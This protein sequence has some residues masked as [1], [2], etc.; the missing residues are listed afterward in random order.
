MSDRGLTSIPAPRCQPLPCPSPP[1]PSFYGPPAP[2]SLCLLS[3]APSPFRSKVQA[4]G[5]Q[6]TF[7]GA[8]LPKAAPHCKDHLP[9]LSLPTV[10]CMTPHMGPCHHTTPSFPGPSPQILIPPTSSLISPIH[11]NRCQIPALA[12]AS[13]RMLWGL[14]PPRRDFGHLMTTPLSPP[15]P[16]IFLLPFPSSPYH[17]PTLPPLKHFPEPPPALFFLS[18]SLGMG[19][20]IFL[21]PSAPLILSVSVTLPLFLCSLLQT[22]VCPWMG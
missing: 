3:S 17:R 20:R 6:K 12:A 9:Q 10:A 15:A 13:L 21:G 14:P 5:P 11:G 8:P 16:A 1:G 4:Q 7:V 18:M 19:D 2:I 22:S